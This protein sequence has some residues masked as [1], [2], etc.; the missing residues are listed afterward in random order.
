MSWDWVKANL[1]IIRIYELRKMN[2]TELYFLV[3]LF[4]KLYKMVLVLSLDEILRMTIQSWKLI[5][6]C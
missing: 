4:I 5:C 3:V 6:L 1:I 2:A